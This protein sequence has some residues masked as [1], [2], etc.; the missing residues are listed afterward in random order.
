MFPVPRDV[1]TL[2]SFSETLLFLHQIFLKGL[3]ARMENWPTLVLGKNLTRLIIDKNL[4][5]S[6]LGKNLPDSNLDKNLPDSNLG[7]K[8]PD[9][10]LGKNLLDSNLGKKLTDSN[11]GKHSTYVVKFS[12]RT[13]RNTSGFESWNKGEWQTEFD[14]PRL[15]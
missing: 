3:I 4:P 6:N 8:L 13:V 7:R 15:S 2:F 14:N 12:T 10:N 11:L 5:D 1:V 9:S